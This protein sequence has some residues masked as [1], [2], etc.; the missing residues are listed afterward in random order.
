[1]ADIT[2]IPTRVYLDQNI[3]DLIVKGHL[4]NLKESFKDT[5]QYQVIYS[6]VTLE[7]ISR[8]A[9]EEDRQQFF[10]CLEDLNA[11]YFWIDQDEKAYFVD[12]RASEL[13]TEHIGNY[14]HFGDVQRSIEQIVFKLLGGRKDDDFATVVAEGRTAMNSLLDS[15]AGSL[16][17]LEDET[18]LYKENLQR[19]ILIMRETYESVADEMVRQ[20]EQ[21]IKD[22][23]TYKGI[24]H[25][26]ELTALGPLQLNNIKPPNVIPQIWKEIEKSDALQ[27]GEVTF[28]TMFGNG[29]WKHLEKEP[30]TVEKINGLYN[31]LNT[32][33]YYSDPKIQKERHFRTFMTD[34]RH[35]GCGSYAHILVSRD[36]RFIKKTAAIYEHLGIGTKIIWIKTEK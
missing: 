27:S 21:S 5:R 22:T 35:A 16:D 1:M 29:L 8:I 3:L 17:E 13:Y 9:N 34:H 33:G 36:E 10:D 30:S 25:F 20:A 14:S 32:I 31:L 26:R 18:K 19:S 7:E 28:E 6:F 2:Q 23:K 12:R 4:A 24:K 15:L 11:L